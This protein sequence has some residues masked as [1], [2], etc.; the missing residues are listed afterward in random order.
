MMCIIVASRNFWTRG[1]V[2]CFKKGF[3]VQSEPEYIKAQYIIDRMLHAVALRYN[4][5]NR[6]CIGGS[7]HGNGGGRGLWEVLRSRTH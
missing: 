7:G 5:I 4:N 6:S 2:P 3:Y 1:G